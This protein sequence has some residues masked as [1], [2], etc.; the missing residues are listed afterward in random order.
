MTTPHSPSQVLAVSEDI[1]VAAGRHLK[2]RLEHTDLCLA[3]RVKDTRH[4]KTLLE[5]HHAKV[6]LGAGEGSWFRGRPCWRNT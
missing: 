3:T 6:G 5:E 2:E 1:L 4:A